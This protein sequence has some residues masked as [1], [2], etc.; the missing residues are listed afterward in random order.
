[1]YHRSLD[2]KYQTPYALKEEMKSQIEKIL[3]KGFIRKTIRLGLLQPFWSQR[4]AQMVSPNL[5]FV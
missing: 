3:D 4:K 1:M 2:P 5:D